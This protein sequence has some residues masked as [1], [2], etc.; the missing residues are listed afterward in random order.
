MEK[1]EQKKKQK[2]S[3]SYALKAVGQHTKTLVENELL[4]KEEAQTFTKILEN[5]VKK[6][7]K[8]EYGV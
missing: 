8:Q 7:I 6:L 5:A 4:T 1:Q 3:P 2:K